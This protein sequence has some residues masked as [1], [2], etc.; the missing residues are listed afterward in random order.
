MAAI[1][2]PVFSGIRPSASE[3]RLQDS[4]AAMAEDVFLRRGLVTPR[5]RQF[6]WSSGKGD[7]AVDTGGF[8]PGSLFRFRRLSEIYGNADY[9]LYWSE[10]SVDVVPGPVASISDS[11]QRHYFTGY[12]DGRAKTFTAD[13]LVEAPTVHGETADTKYPYVWFYLGLDAPSTAPTVDTSG[14]VLPTD[15]VVSGR[16]TQVTS[17]TLYVTGENSRERHGHDATSYQTSS[18]YFWRATTAPV[19]TQTIGGV[20]DP[21]GYGFVVGARFRVASIVDANNITV[22]GLAAADVV[23]PLALCDNYWYYGSSSH[24]TEDY[25]SRATY[26]Y[27][28]VTKWQRARFELPHGATVYCANHVFQVDD[29]IRVVAVNQ[30]MACGVEGDFTLSGAAGSKVRTAT[31]TSPHTGS[32]VFTGDLSYVIERNGGDIDPTISS[33]GNV[34]TIN[35]VA[36]AYVYTWVT[37]LGEESAPSPPSDVVTLTPGD[38]IGVGGFATPPSDHVRITHVRI[39]RAATGTDSTEFLLVDEIGV[40]QSSYTDTVDDSQLGEALPSESWLP[41]DPALR[42]LVA[43]PSG[44]VVGFYDNVVSISEPGYCHAFPDEYKHYLDYQVV[45]L[46]VLGSSVIALTDGTPYIISGAHPRQM[47]ARKTAVRHP[48]L[49][50]RAIVN[51]GDQVIYPSPAG[52]VRITTGGTEVVTASHY[53]KED[54]AG[55]VGGVLASSRTLRAWFHDEQ[56]ILDA[57]FVLNGTT[58]ETKLLFDFKGESGVRISTFTEDVVAGFYDPGYGEFFYVT[59]TSAH[60]TPTISGSLPSANHQPLL[61]WNYL[62][63]ETDAQNDYVVATWKSKT[64]ELA[65]PMAPAAARVVCRRKRQNGSYDVKAHVDVKVYGVRYGKWDTAHDVL[66]DETTLVSSATLISGTPTDA[67]FTEHRSKPFRVSGNGLYDAL[68]FELTMYGPVEVE[69]VEIAES[70]DELGSE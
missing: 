49:D 45:G 38:P 21:E 28:A 54:W 35:S 25:Y 39:Y 42:G 34:T 40:A 27:P 56:Y 26:T 1:K 59:N 64:F 65:A 6:V 58:T 16:I 68:R 36:R 66:V 62:H 8:T 47:T 63:P 32:F 55:V 50:K 22:T 11:D 4:D 19:G 18:P 5:P 43:H 23:I 46:S 48:C 37:H 69:Y 41:P 10:N 33:T 13:S 51:T 9:W 61:R 31:P 67:A 44:A 15:A 53:T 57:V 3:V 12:G 24:G 52:L 30:P 2:V 20:D 60:E 17:T 7:P 14:V 70:M 29:I